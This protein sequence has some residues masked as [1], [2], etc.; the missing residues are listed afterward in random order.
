MVLMALISAPTIIV[1]FDDTTDV[2]S[3]YSIVEEEENHNVKLVFKNTDQESNT[4]FDDCSNTHGVGYMY[5]QY[6]KPHLN[7]ISPPPDFI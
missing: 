1:S 3:F 2:T 7:L 6:P 5:K 4:L